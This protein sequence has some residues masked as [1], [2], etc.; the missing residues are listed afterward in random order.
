[1]SIT[2]IKMS[3]NEIITLNLDDANKLTVY[4]HGIIINIKHLTIFHLF[5]KYILFLIGA[6][7]TSWISNNR[8]ILFVRYFYFLKINL[9]SIV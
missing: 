7:I 9:F 6:T 1:L 3:D 8:E 4:L 2:Q 5:S